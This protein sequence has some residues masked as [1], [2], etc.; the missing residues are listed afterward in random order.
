MPHARSGP[1]QLEVAADRA[2]LAA[3]LDAQGRHREAE[4]TLRDAL[5][6]VER[7]LGRDHYEVALA[8]E[9]LAAVVRRGGDEGQAFALCERSLAI[10]RR[11]LGDDHA[12][13]AG[14]LCAFGACPCDLEHV[15][16]R[17]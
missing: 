11:I 10:K 5:S 16:R 1:D 8:L 9:R 6:V 2:A 14:T 4:V 7:V 15:R 17:R 3:I 12:D 13:V